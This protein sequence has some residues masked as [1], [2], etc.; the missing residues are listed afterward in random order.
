M[1]GGGVAFDEC[2]DLVAVALGH[3]HIGQNDVRLIALDTFDRLLP[4]S[5]R[6]HLDVLI[7]ERQFDDPLDRDAVVR[8]QQLVRHGSMIP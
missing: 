8:Q 3:A 4:V 7:S 6:D 2:R 5:D 1:R